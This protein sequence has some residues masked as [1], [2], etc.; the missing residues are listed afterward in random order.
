MTQEERSPPASQDDSLV[1]AVGWVGEIKPPASHV[2][3]L[4]AVVGWVNKVKP[5]ASQNDSLVVVV[6]LA[7]DPGG[8]DVHQRV[9]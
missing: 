2:N 5:P 8:N 3:S 4:V 7:V 1:V 6:V 9:E